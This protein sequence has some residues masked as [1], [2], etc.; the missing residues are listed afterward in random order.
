MQIINSAVDA[1]CAK[2]KSGNLTKVKI[3]FDITVHNI[4]STV[5]AHC[6]KSGNLAHVKIHFNITV[7]NIN[8]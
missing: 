8:S 4:N 2:A 7:H 1:H 3:Y 5:D 6:A